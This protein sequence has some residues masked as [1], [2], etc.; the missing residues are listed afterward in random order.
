VIYYILTVGKTKPYKI[1]SSSGV[2]PKMSSI[3]TN[4]SDPAH[5]LLHKHD[6][7]TMSFTKDEENSWVS[8]DLGEGRSLIVNYYCL[9]HGN[10]TGRYRLLSWDFEGS[11]DGSEWTVLMVHKDDNSL[12][13]STGVDAA[14]T[15]GEGFIVAAW[16]VEGVNQAYRHFRI[17]ITGKSSSGTHHMCCAGIE[18]WGRLL[19]K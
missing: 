13:D 18:L 14:R 16:E 4:L 19:S 6:G 12:P 8:I 10:N 7:S 3:A 11:N 17:R 2:T 9:R 15:G 5:L 1:S